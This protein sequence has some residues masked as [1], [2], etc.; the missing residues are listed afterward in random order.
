MA[1]IVI[2]GSLKFKPQKTK[3][4]NKSTWSCPEASDCAELREHLT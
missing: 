2:D 3:Q 1:G 4:T